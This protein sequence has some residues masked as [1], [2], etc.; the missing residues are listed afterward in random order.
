[1]SIPGDPIPVSNLSK[2]AIL[3]RAPGPDL[4]EV[5]GFGLAVIEVSSGLHLDANP[6]YC[7]LTGYDLAEL[8]QKTLAELIYPE[9]RHALVSGVAELRAGLG[10][11]WLRVVQVEDPGGQRQVLIEDITSRKLGD[12]KWASKRE[13]FNLAMRAT[14][15]GVWDWDLTRGTGYFSERYYELLGYQL[16]QLAPTYEA[17]VELI[18]PEDRDRMIECIAQHLV[19]R[20]PYDSECRMRHANG[21]YKW[22]RCQGQAQRDAE[23]KPV[24]M[25]GSITDLT[26]QKG[27]ERETREAQVRHLFA[28]ELSGQVAYEFDIEQ[29]IATVYGDADGVL[30]YS[31]AELRPGLSFWLTLV[32]PEDL[33][34]LQS[35]V[36]RLIH[37]DQAF[38]I[39]YRLRLKSGEYRWIEDACRTFWNEEKTS[40]R[41]IGRLSDVSE[42]VKMEQSL[43]ESNSELESRIRERTLGLS[44]ANSELQQEIAL[45]KGAEERLHRSEERLLWG[46]SGSKYGLWECILGANRSLYVDENY[47]R[48]LGYSHDEICS[49]ISSQPSRLVHPDDLE[50]MR[51]RVADNL[52]GKLPYFEM[53]HRLQA[54]SG[55]WTW[56]LS[57]GQVG[58]L[59][60]GMEQ[61]MVGTICDISSQIDLEEQLRLAVEEAQKA[62]LAKSSFLAAMSHEIR[63]PLNGII[64]LG[65]LLLGTT[66]DSEQHDYADKITSC[67]DHLRLML[68]DILDFS[69]IEAGKLAMEKIPFA[70]SQVI[71]EAVRLVAPQAKSKGLKLS[72]DLSGLPDQT[73]LGD[74]GRLRQILLNLL[75]NAVKFCAKG[76][77][78]VSAEVV[79]TRQDGI[80]V[81]IEVTDSGIGIS[82]EHLRDLF[83][84]FN[85]ADASTTRK[86]GG[87]GLGLVISK[88]L[89][90]LQGGSMGVESELGAGSRFWFTIPYECVETGA[91]K[92]V[93]AVA[94]GSLAGLRILVAEDNAVNQLVAKKLLSKRGAIVDLAGNGSAAVGLA[95][96]NS[97][98]LILMDCHMPEMD[99]LE[100]TR[101]IRA[102]EGGLRHTPVVALTAAATLSE[103]EACFE[104]GMDGYLSKPLDVERLFEVVRRHALPG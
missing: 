60:E 29:G 75:S 94:V 12:L 42:R 33:E 78:G 49:L 95:A 93:P 79:E 52:D 50:E 64:G 16:G 87:T 85:Q 88:Q 57:R 84:S 56:V 59:G 98:D 53:R 86:F 102:A 31:A 36:E 17:W 81:R 21:E 92:D 83:Q 2:L 70:V 91:V 32:H 28:I 48:V 38:C 14:H 18:H 89:T 101:G 77:V 9:D 41:L 24:R 13:R 27:S 80:T 55:S 73:V 58:P 8:R 66:L 65:N 39:V 10:E 71:D 3:A 19:H 15:Q 63:T 34:F 23:G 51:A 54:K 69:K 47:A 26:D 37:Q 44:M 62:N 46:L 25:S 5:A 97:Y 100:A 7:R 11:R 20:A 99:G 6:T 76:S 103:R 1:M 68:N 43:R 45:R 22:F 40:R 30:G 72:C 4:L 61:R 96:E 82:R 104:A 90:E 74:P 35:T 67:A